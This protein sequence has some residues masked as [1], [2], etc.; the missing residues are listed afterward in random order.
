MKLKGLFLTA[1]V[2]LALSHSVVFAELEKEMLPLAA[3]R[4]CA[5][6]HTVKPKEAKPNKAGE[7]IKPFG[8]PYQMV[9]ERYKD[10]EGAFETLVKVVNSGSN[11]YVRH[12]KDETS[13]LAMPPNSIV[14]KEG[15]AEILVKWILSLAD[16]PT[17]TTKAAK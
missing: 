14:L 15:D 8:P 16:E 3:E 10:K 2:L 11:V 17:D 1:S 12:W 5:A 13:G 9:A 7:V 4:G 6:C